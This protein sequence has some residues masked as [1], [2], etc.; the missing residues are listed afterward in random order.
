M[1]GQTTILEHIRAVHG[2]LKPTLQTVADAVLAD[3]DTVRRMNLRQLASHSGVSEASI[4]RF[5]RGIGLEN[6]RDFGLRLAEISPTDP[7]KVHPATPQGVYDN[8]G[9]T[10]TAETIL[11]K[12]A[13][14][15]IDVARS[16]LA[17]LDPEALEQ[18]ARMIVSAG[19]VLFLAAGSSCLAAESGV[20][21]FGRIGIPA[22][23]H[24]DRNNQTILAASLPKDAL[25]IAISDSG[26]TAQ[27]VEATQAARN[28]GLPAI[29][30]TSYPESPLAK[31][32]DV[33]LATPSAYEPAG[34]EPLYES[35]VAKYGQLL[36]V[37]ALYSLTAVLD[38]DRALEHLGRGDP[39][40]KTSRRIAHDDD[41]P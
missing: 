25:V 12:I 37:D 24:Q 19:P 22:M 10:D 11:S 18:A 23:F 36:A 33:T 13:H 3:P 39:H 40:I 5:V 6:Y 9:R 16:G 4:S 41:R 30:I 1:A 32:A 26:R 27:T 15:Q 7:T 8:I 17:T 2:N 38:Y 31:L 14:R 34:G 21:R 29:V 20:V 35:M 28:S